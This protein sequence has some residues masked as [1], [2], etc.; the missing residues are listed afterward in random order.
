[1]PTIYEY[2]GITIKFYSHEHDP[3]HVHAK[4]GENEVRVELHEKNGVIYDVEYKE[5]SGKFSP[6][7]MRD[8]RVFISENKN[9]I[10]FAWQQS[11]KQNVK[12]KPIKITKRIK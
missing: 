12:L 11:F 2:L 10:L 4:Y 3:I 8:L 6:T 9:A 7:K 5:M 1:M